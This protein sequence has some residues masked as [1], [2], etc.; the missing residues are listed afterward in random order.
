MS[1]IISL[2]K[3]SLALGLRMHILHVLD[4]AMS[5]RKW[6]LSRKDNCSGLDKKALM[7]AAEAAEAMQWTMKSWNARDR[8]GNLVSDTPTT[9]QQRQLL[10]S[11]CTLKYTATS[12]QF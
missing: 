7:A 12:K 9:K 6:L 2:Y 10:E 11:T 4:L 3:Y 5:L 8:K 1:D